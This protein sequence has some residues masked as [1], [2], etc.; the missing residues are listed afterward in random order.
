MTM[1]VARPTNPILV[2]SADPDDP[3]VVV[4]LKQRL[5]LYLDEPPDVATATA[6]YRMYVDAFGES[7]THYRSTAEG[8]IQM[9]PRPLTG[10]RKRA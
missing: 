4:E 10:R 1:S 6:L 9:G 2:V 3:G 7:I 5:V 8:R